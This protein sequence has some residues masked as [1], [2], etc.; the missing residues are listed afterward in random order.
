[1]SMSGQLK[2]LR[3]AR[4]L[5]LE[6]LAKQCGLTKGYLS[7]IENGRQT[8]AVSTI[9]G[10]AAALDTDIADLLGT[11][12][13]DQV[14]GLDMKKSNGSGSK[15]PEG[16][17]F[18]P[19]LNNFRNKF[20]SP[21]LMIIEKGGTKTFSHDSEEFLYVVEGSVE[22]IYKGHTHPLTRGDSVYF[23]SREKHSFQN[24]H[25]EKAVLVAV[26]YNY[27]RF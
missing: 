18:Q 7:R 5:T 21:F 2:H 10:I 3:K 25:D 12:P 14:S 15:T 17:F 8:P 24:R 27:R 11:T 6:E 22:F 1:M 19:L 20:M 9:Q 4:G 13:K 23:D 16:Y 26:N